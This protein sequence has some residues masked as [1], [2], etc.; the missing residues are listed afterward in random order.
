M[1]GA[2]GRLPAMLDDLLVHDPH[3]QPAPDPA[4]PT[5]LTSSGQAFPVRNRRLILR[6]RRPDPPMTP[7][8]GS[9]RSTERRAR[10]AAQLAGQ[11]CRDSCVQAS[12]FGLAVTSLG[13]AD[14][15]RPLRTST[16]PK[17]FW[18]GCAVRALRLASGRETGARHRRA[19]RRQPAVPRQGG[20]ITWTHHSFPRRGPSR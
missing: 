7:Q 5:T 11:E 6:R 3:H 20:R 19:R 13:Y 1:A 17:P 18:G 9:E 10:P 8:P 16:R 4:I 2:T 15:R 14:L 12:A